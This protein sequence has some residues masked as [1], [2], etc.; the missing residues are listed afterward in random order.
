MKNLIFQRLGN[1][2]QRSPVQ[3]SYSATGADGRYL[4]MAPPEQPVSRHLLKCGWLWTIY[5]PSTAEES[6]NAS[7]DLNG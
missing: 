7:P 2:G 1:S 4:E 6:L 5:N 3:L